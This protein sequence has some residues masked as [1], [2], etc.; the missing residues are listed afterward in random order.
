MERQMHREHM[1]I[2]GFGIENLLGNLE[3]TVSIMKEGM[4]TMKGVVTKKKYKPVAKKVKPVITNLPG[5]YR[6]MREIQGNPLELI[7]RHA[8]SELADLCLLGL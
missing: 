1:D 7:Q 4:V 6:I 3:E 8:N 2:P 5:Q